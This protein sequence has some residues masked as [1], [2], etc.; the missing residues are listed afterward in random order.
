M[1]ETAR[2]CRQ[3][4]EPVP[5][6]VL[7]CAKCGADFLAD[8]QP[9]ESRSF[10]E[11]VKSFLY[12]C[13]SCGSFVRTEDTSCDKCGAPLGEDGASVSATD[14]GAP[15]E[16]PRCPECA[17]AVPAGA[18]TCGVCGTSLAVADA[19]EPAPSPSAAVAVGKDEALED[20]EQSVREDERGD[21]RVGSAANVPTARPPTVP[22]IAATKGAD[23]GL[24]RPRVPAPRGATPVV[25]PRLAPWREFAVI[26]TGL[27]T[28][29]AAIAAAVNAPG[30]EW[31]QL[32]LFGVLFG[33]GLILTIPAVRGVA[34]SLP[35]LLWSSGAALLLSVPAVALT[36]S[37]P[38]V[39]V[40]IL[41][42]GAGGGLVAVAAWRLPRGIG[43]YLP[44][45][46]GLLLLT[47]AASVPI[48]QRALGDPIVTT[49][50]WL[51][52]GGLAAGPS[53]LVARRRGMAGAATRALADAEEAL[54]KR[55]YGKALR[56]YDETLDLSG[57][58]GRDPNGALYGKGAA[59]VAIGQLDDAL[60]VLDRA[61][62]ANPRNEVA[63]V[64]K[65]TALTRLGRLEDALKCYNSAIK[66]NSRYEV[67]WNNK[68][69]ALS[70]LGKSE[71]ALQCYEQALA[72]DPSYRVAWVNKGYI[73]AKLGRFDEASECADRALQLTA[74]AS[75]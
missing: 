48:A 50:L 68:G 66:V 3:C 37:P 30:H 2:P 21:A 19:G 56:L 67:A 60:I 39:P 73:L 33:I 70:R 18:S 53:I 15:S 43:V 23:K 42:V 49:C 35:F 22:E 20:L 5:D 40:A 29:P 61:L 36:A 12:L 69:N 59:L 75:A 51:V 58:L 4:R 57:R 34:R 25:P 9:Q 13:P 24:P 71:W 62:S 7:R 16:P 52:G 41:L 47:V 72:L 63:W 45:L 17:A 31:G 6:G 44:W 54:S 38:V 55:D 32:F 26:V 1:P 14:E 74:V 64:N 27:A 10:D 8:P 65:G 11:Q 28:P 46:S